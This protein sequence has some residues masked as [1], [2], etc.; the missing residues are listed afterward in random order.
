MG[1]V[2]TLAVLI[3]VALAPP[4]SAARTFAPPG[5]AEADQ[6]FQTL[7]GSAGAASP[8]LAKTPEDAVREGKLKAGTERALRRGAAG[9][10]VASLVAKTAPAGAVTGGGR[11]G[12][13]Q[14]GVLATPEKQGLGALL[15][16]MLVAGAA[17]A[18]AFALDRRR[19]RATR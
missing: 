3:A 2:T 16:L 4:A 1:K 14:T 5:N 19:R 10:A 12:G 9:G 6:Y 17:A 18:L 11:A 15:P 8:A 13:P 7:P